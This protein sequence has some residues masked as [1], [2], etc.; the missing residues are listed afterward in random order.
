MSCGSSE[1]RPLLFRPYVLPCL[2]LTTPQ[3]HACT[4]IH[5]PPMYCAVEH[6]QSRHLHGR[7]G[8][9]NISKICSCVPSTGHYSFLFPVSGFKNQWVGHENQQSK[10]HV[11]YKYV[12][13]TAASICIYSSIFLRV[14][15]KRGAQQV[16]IL[17][18]QISHFLTSYTQWF[19]EC[20]SPYDA[21]SDIP[22][23]VVGALNF[24][25]KKFILKKSNE[26]SLIFYFF[27][28]SPTGDEILCDPLPAVLPCW[29]LK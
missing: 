13:V 22:C 19:P 24:M 18:W 3:T 7:P 27:I 25:R 16:Q 26:H 8:N 9:S 10:L 6:V 12:W 21:L 17:E 11:K 1:S 28:V 20:E 4:P 15:W 29:N 2:I 23:W 14:S 5:S